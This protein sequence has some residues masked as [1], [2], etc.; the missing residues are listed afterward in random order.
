MI[1]G[2]DIRQVV[3][4]NVDT[5]VKGF[6][7]PKNPIWIDICS[8]ICLAVRASD[9]GIETT[10]TDM[11]F[12]DIGSEEFGGMGRGRRIGTSRLWT[13]T[14]VKMPVIPEDWKTKDRPK[15]KQARACKLFIIDGMVRIKCI[16]ELGLK[17]IPRSILWAMPDIVLGDM[18]QNRKEMDFV[19]LFVKVAA[20]AL[21]A[22]NGSVAESTLP[23]QVMTIAQERTTLAQGL[24][25]RMDVIP[26]CWETDLKKNSD[27]KA[28][29]IDAR[30]SPDQRQET[31]STAWS[32]SRRD[33]T[34]VS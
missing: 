31:L 20:R 21:N 18:D 28:I 9:I 26:R 24:P 12:V 14:R 19:G 5:V 3:K 16:N 29:E 25:G 33:S 2:S 6:P 22:A 27:V 10:A 17:A 23:Q 30:K 11:E 13:Y 32:E 15:I 34:I 7:G 4:E 1:H 8:K